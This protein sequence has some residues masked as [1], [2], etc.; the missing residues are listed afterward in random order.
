[1]A[2]DRVGIVAGVTEA[3][4]RQGGNV[5]AMSQTVMRGYFTIIITA[6]FSAGVKGSALRSEVEGSGEPGELMVSIK[7][8]DWAAACDPVVKDSDV[9]VLSIMGRDRPGVVAKITSFLASR[10]INIV[11]LWTYTEDG[12]VV[13]ISQVMVERGLDVGQLQID[14][15]GLFKKSGLA[16]RFQH[17]NIFIATNKVEFPIRVAKV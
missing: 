15:E 16:V 8:W 11:D 5:D 6:G 3:I 14:L 12:Q 10:N 13:F 9:F 7:E 4:A 17:E 2:R 1:M